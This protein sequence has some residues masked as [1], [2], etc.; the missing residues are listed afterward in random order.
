MKRDN[1]TLF[2][3]IRYLIIYMHSFS[4]YFL[5]H[6]H[7]EAVAT[8]TYSI[9]LSS[10][11]VNDSK[12]SEE[13]ENEP[14]QSNEQIPIQFSETEPPPPQPADL[15]RDSTINPV[16]EDSQFIY[17]DEAQRLICVG[18]QFDDIP[19]SVIEAYA[20]KTKVKHL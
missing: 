17:D 6:Q 16:D 1:K 4:C 20:L 3:S 18:S 8:S 15:S 11:S 2:I 9:P 10:V 12:M 5:L 7:F 13:M 14:D 19:Q